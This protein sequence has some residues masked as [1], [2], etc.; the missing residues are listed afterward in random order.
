MKPLDAV[1][2]VDT[3]VEILADRRQEMGA[4][5]P[6]SP[7]AAKAAREEESCPLHPIRPTP[8]GST[9]LKVGPPTS[10]ATAT[11]Y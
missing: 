7:A 4:G 9:S 6:S 2:S 3:I 10:T 1:Q 8:K 11:T 5:M